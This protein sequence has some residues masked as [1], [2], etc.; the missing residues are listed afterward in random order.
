[1]KTRRRKS[2]NAPVQEVCFELHQRVAEMV[3]FID[4][5]ADMVY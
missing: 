5:V 4:V 2:P 3:D 1:M